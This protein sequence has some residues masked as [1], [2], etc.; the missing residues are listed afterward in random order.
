M[1][2][3]NR[4]SILARLLANENIAVEQTNHHTAF[5]DVENRIL[6]LP[7]WKD[8]DNDLY[9]LLVGHE[10]GH[11]LETPA[12]GWHSCT[13]DIPGCP[14]DYVN[15]VEDI[16]IEKLVLRRYPGLLGS[17]MRGYQNLLDRDFFGL[18]KRG[19]NT[20]PFMD[21]L[22]VFSKSRGL[23]NV[24]FS[25]D[26]RPYVDMAMAVETWADVI[27]VCTKLLAFVKSKKEEEDQRR[28]D[29][30]NGEGQASETEAG[31]NSEKK[32]R[33]S[34][35]VITDKK[36]DDAEAGDKLTKEEMED[37][38]DGVEKGEIEVEF[39]RS[40]DSSDSESEDEEDGD[41]EEEEAED[42]K[43]GEG[44]L[45][46]SSGGLNT[47]P[48]DGDIEESETDRSFRENFMKKLVDSVNAGG[49]TLYVK[50]PTK[51]QVDAAISTYEEV[52]NSRKARNFSNGSEEHFK[53]FE[54]ATR[55]QVMMMVKEFEMR[56]AAFRSARA[57]TS[58]KGSLDVNLL[59]K[60]KYEDN[61][62]KQVTYLADTQSHGMVMLIDYSS[63]M[64]GVIGNV[65]KQL[66]VTVSFCKR[67]GIPFEVYGFTSMQTGAHFDAK[68]QR[69]N[70]AM[71][72]QFLASVAMNDCHVF[73]LIDSTMPKSIYAEAYRAL[74]SQ[75]TPS[76]YSYYSSGFGGLEGMNG[77]PL[78]TA[79]LCMVDVIDR[80]KAK[81]NVQK[82]NF[83]T[84]TDGEGMNISPMRG[85]DYA[86][87]FNG[88]PY[89]EVV[90][91][92]NGKTI[93]LGSDH[94]GSILEVLRKS[95]VK[96]INYYLLEGTRYM[97]GVIYGN[98]KLVAEIK[99]NDIAVSDN[100]G[101]Y[102]RRFFVNS[103][104]RVLS[105][106][107]DDMN[108]DGSA[109]TAKIAKE[110]SKHA[111]SKKNARTIAAKFA[112]IVS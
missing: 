33:P 27:D 55:Q 23:V 70:K 38:L 45:G 66:L 98:P 77:T 78:N 63:S 96:T 11:A 34:K 47:A 35:I 65:I 102:D 89:N 58:T 71:K 13:T 83:V 48:E 31:K 59:H 30:A 39:D 5:F 73:K 26:E 44:D 29:E 25:S 3:L 104:S 8:I 82:M 60:Y 75:T 100:H 32:Q 80:F 103:R 1:S 87:S 74:W 90:V 54:A 28:A 50:G 40:N 46:A 36:S 19:I 41:E 93:K 37:I 4:K 10:V 22:N 76:G 84:L 43:K 17:F 2:V 110:F 69:M 14:R 6:G 51:A 101:G 94:T 85:A 21:R 86:P 20:Y 67:V 49:K 109:S 16:R 81:H 111:D 15:I 61:L 72:Q 107:V 24:P 91:D 92:I 62:F 64:S 53:K 99:K 18:S 52:R 106:A 97:P 68:I 42:G 12:D 79:L 88:R 108:F 112:E 9:D 57:R 95:G 7:F 105:G 56:K